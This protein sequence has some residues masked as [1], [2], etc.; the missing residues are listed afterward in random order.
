RVA[1]GRISG[2]GTAIDIAA[3]IRWAVDHGAR[4]LNMSLGGYNTTFAERDAVA[5]A[6]A[7]GAV[8]VAAMGNDNTQEPS[9]P[10]AYPGVLAVGAID[11]LD[12]RASF[13]NSGGHIGVV[14]PG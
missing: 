14:A 13:S 12:H 2:S 6:V 10:A 3:G 9:Y 4:I 7:R 11:D 5:Y 1:D 8:V